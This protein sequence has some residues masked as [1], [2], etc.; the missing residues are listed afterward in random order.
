MQ[1]RERLR[2]CVAHQITASRNGFKDREMNYS[3]HFW[4][5]TMDDSGNK[6]LDLEF[7]SI[8]KRLVVGLDGFYECSAC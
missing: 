3:Q 7:H 2:A 8:T 1:T 5:R 6:I 4:R